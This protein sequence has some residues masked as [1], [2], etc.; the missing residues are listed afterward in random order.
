MKNS[1]SREE[2]ITEVEKSIAWHE[3]HLVILREKLERLQ[4][5]PPPARGKVGMATVVRK[6][7]EQGISA[8]QL[9]EIVE[10][11]KTD[12]EG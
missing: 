1:R 9:L 7:K 2:K 3:H 4:N 11:I 10:N 12:T 8:K 6:A 5:P